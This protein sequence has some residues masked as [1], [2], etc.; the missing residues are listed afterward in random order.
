MLKEQLETLELHLIKE[1]MARQCSFSLGKRM[2]YQLEPSFD[3][4]FVKRELKRAQEALRLVIHHGSPPFGGVSDI[5]ESIDAAMKDMTLSAQELRIIADQGRIFEQ[6]SRYRKSS[7]IEAPAIFEL[8]DSFSDT[9]SLSTAIEA[10]I[11]VNFEVLDHASG[12][13]KSIR[14]NIR[15]L[16]SE[17]NAQV[18]KVISHHAAKLSDTVT[19]M[20]NDR[21][22]LLVKISE[23]HTVKGFVH[24]E[25][26]SGQSAYVEPES[27]LI[28]N[29]R[30]QTLRSKEQDEIQKI[31]FEL[32]QKVKLQGNALSANMET[33]AILD[34]IFA[35]AMWGKQHDACIAQ[36][37]EKGSH[38]YL[39]QARHPLIAQEHVVANT[40]EIK[41]PYHA[42]L[43]TGSNTGG[44]TV[45]LKT[46]GLFVSMTMCGMPIPCEE[47]IVP[48]FDD[49]YVDIGDDQ[50][51]VESLSTFSSH[52]S[53]LAYICEH[54]SK[55][56]LVLLDEL[57]SGT[58][59]KEGEALAIAVLEY[60]RAQS[61]TLVATTH[62][63]QLK[64]YGTRCD[65]VLLACVEFNMEE[66][67]PTYRYLE[68]LSGQSN[69]FAIAHRYHLK[70]EIIERARYYKEANRTDNEELM[71]KLEAQIL[72]NT[73]RKEEL[74]KQLEAWEKLN[75]EL[76]E[77]RIKIMKEKTRI[78]EEAKQKVEEA[79]E[80]AREQAQIII[81]E[82]KAKQDDVKPHELTALK[83][84]LNRLS[85]EVSKEEETHRDET[86][87]VGDYVQIVK[88]GYYG[89]ILS[90]Q[91]EKA[92][93]FANGMKMN[94]KLQELTH[95]QKPKQQ[96]KRGGVSKSKSASFPMECN[97]IGMYVDE[98]I[99]VL[100]KYIDNA[101]MAKMEHVR[102]IHGVGTG[103]L[104]KAVHA[105]LKKHPKVEEFRMGG[106]GEGGLG[107]SVVTLKVKGK[108]QNG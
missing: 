15:S 5:K 18:Q 96:K 102:I 49:I 86:F 77:Q 89:E 87:E 99:P 107:A 48:L 26:A 101:L 63:S 78:K 83:S 64:A 8:I 103:A 79:V 54:A 50:S 27:L 33:I 9:Q 28:L 43:I 52:L 17:I 75:R 90:I 65:D 92:C 69:A 85:D 82:L 98:A 68:G 72:E 95:A 80:E 40:Y 73:R 104:R 76:E 93:V 3:Y 7:E 23:K 105:Y 91:K 70:D 59:P 66:M 46:I 24:G 21:I 30:M 57:G 6:I 19:A 42:L 53:K 32:S 74:A 47:A 2:I 36:L 35:K 29:N 106:Q 22:C 14:K 4:L 45:T 16:S 94:T 71:E 55:H 1:Q 41:E 44:K 58:D 11:S 56:S 51:I 97:L 61:C 38:L 67:R 81:D 100:D 13:L 39:K 88:L 31:L 108:K 10:C 25:S 37:Q 62:F 34:A 84:E 20:R 60:L 12:E